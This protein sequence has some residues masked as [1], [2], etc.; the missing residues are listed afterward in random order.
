MVK[1]GNSAWGRSPAAMAACMA[2]SIA[3]C[4]L[5]TEAF[6]IFD[7]VMWHVL[8]FNILFVFPDGKWIQN[9]GYEKRAAPSGAFRRSCFFY[10]DMQLV[11]AGEIGIYIQCIADI[12]ASALVGEL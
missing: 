12:H 5:S 4:R 11:K 1:S 3:F 2:F 7:M 9:D 8:P 10:R 6:T